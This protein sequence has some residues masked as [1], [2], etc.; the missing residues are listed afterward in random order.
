MSLLNLF[1]PKWKHPDPAVRVAGVRELKNAAILTL[2]VREDSSVLVRQAALEQLRDPELLAEIARSDTDLN[3]AAAG[4]ISDTRL[5]VQ[6]AQTASSPSVRRSAVAR[7]GDKIVLQQIAAFDPHEAV[8]QEAALKNL[9]SDV[10][11][12]LLRTALA[13]LAVAQQQQADSTEFS[14]SLDSVCGALVTD[15]RF[16]IAAVV[17]PHEP[18]VVAAVEKPEAQA[19]WVELVGSQRGKEAVNEPGG[20]TVYRIKV[21]RHADDGYNGSIEERRLGHH[22]P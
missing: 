16:R 12:Q 8:R 9:S 21:W 3:L 13:N 2:L 1:R 5:L 6:V 22:H 17:T 7:I 14:G 15:R 10:R 19:R 18:G 4:R 11:H 20:E